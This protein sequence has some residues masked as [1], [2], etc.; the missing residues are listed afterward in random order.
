MYRIEI[1]YCFIVHELPLIILEQ[2]QLRDD[3]IYLGLQICNMGVSLSEDAQ[4][5]IDPKMSQV[6]ADTLDIFYSTV[7]LQHNINFPRDSIDTR[8]NPIIKEKNQVVHLF[9]PSTIWFKL[10]EVCTFL[11]MLHLTFF[12]GIF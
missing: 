5:L 6:T 4:L 10:L 12:L 8:T 9:R 11:L 7:Q 1:S 3:F 2:V